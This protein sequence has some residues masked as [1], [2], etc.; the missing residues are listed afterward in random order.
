M[1]MYETSKEVRAV[2]EQLI[3]SNHPKLAGLKI[4]YL[5]R[6]EAAVSNG[7][8][9]VAMACR[10]DDR[11]W[12]LTRTDFIIEVAKD[13]W[14]SAE[15]RFREAVL[16]HELCH[17]GLNCDENGAVKKDAKTNRAKGY[18]RKHDMEEFEDVVVRHGSY[19]KD[20]RSF[21]EAYAKRRQPVK[22]KIETPAG[23]VATAEIE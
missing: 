19:R 17:I 21:I 8:V 5:F 18:I 3:S 13:V 16:D 4:E 15:P 23:G 22:G 1:P 9:T 12:A 11:N 6:D 2:A 7:K 20:L 14:D 10:V